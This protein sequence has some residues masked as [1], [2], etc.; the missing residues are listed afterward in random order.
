MLISIAIIL[1]LV[2]V[3]R[4]DSRSVAIWTAV[5]LLLPGIGIFVYLCFGQTI[6]RGRHFAIKNLT[7]EN[8]FRIKEESLN[9]LSRTKTPAENGE[10][11]RFAKSMMATGN[12]LY[13]TNN[14]LDLFSRGAE[15]FS[16][17]FSDLRG[18]EKFIHAEYYIIR[19]DKLSNE[20]MDILIER[21]KAGVEVKLMVDAIGFNGGLNKKI[22]QL[23][24]AGGEFELFHRAATVLLSPK[25]NNRNHRKL[26][27]IDGKIGYVSGFNIGD[28]YLGGNNESKWRDT[29][30]RIEG[31]SVM[32][33][34]MRFFMDW[35]YASGRR[36][37]LD[38]ESGEKYFPTDESAQYGC[39]IM[40]LISGGPDTKNNPIELQYLKIISTAK[41]TLFIHTPYLVPSDNV[42]K[43]LILSARSGVDVRV[44]MPDRPDHLFVF[45]ASI[46][47][48]GE[49]MKNGVR[50]YRYKGGFVHSK[51]LVADA[52]YCSVGS[53]NLDQRSMTLNFET[54]AMI[55]SKRIGE[56]MQK[57]F[58]SD[59]DRCVEY[60]QKEYDMLTKWQN[61]KM[62][63][64]R[65]FSPWA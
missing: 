52:E 12:A 25:K 40:Q 60:S 53:A 58:L 15:F 7:D 28:E 24:K 38:A 2:F 47:N 6:Y 45:W 55:Y 35:G 41:K 42:M 29:G 57:A 64:A 32:A 9:E 5:M 30:L 65:L 23:K 54:N 16:Q 37:Y 20:F 27:V 26:M 59:L 31:Y 21:A 17:M 61:L 4:S 43:C 19:N 18:A 3:E 50:I 11:I 44:I 48:A 14:K 46:M 51:T 49:L 36:L 39:D 1:F 56:Q 22:K 8:L 62:S 63:I 13:S 34:N 10:E 33:I